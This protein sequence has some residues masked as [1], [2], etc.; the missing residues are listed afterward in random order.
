M[1]DGAPEPTVAPDRGAAEA[2][3]VAPVVAPAHPVRE[4][5]RSN[6]WIWIVVSLLVLGLLAWVLLSAL[7]GDDEDGFSQS[8]N[9]APVV[10]R[11]QPE[12]MVALE[13]VAVDDPAEPIVIEEIG[14]PAP[15]E[16]AEQPDPPQRS[17]ED[18]TSP[19]AGRG[20]SM[21]ASQADA[22][23][24]RWI[25]SRNHYGVPSSCIA[26]RNLGFSNRGYTIELQATGCPGRRDGLLGR[27]RVDTE[28][29]RVYEQKGDGRFLAP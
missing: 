12:G 10:D 24:I 17:P 14:R 7:P 28:T 13:S 27:W 1:G 19:A 4:G 11:E 5:A 26:V 18:E 8:S 21:T 6:A 3:A 9:E 29:S 15:A 23:L 2:P 22:V 20:G 25:R 16:S